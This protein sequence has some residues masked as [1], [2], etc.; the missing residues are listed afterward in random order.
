MSTVW[1]CDCDALNVMFYAVKQWSQYVLVESVIRMSELFRTYSKNHVKGWNSTAYA[2]KFPYVLHDCCCLL[3]F[4]ADDS[5]SQRT[6]ILATFSSTISH[7]HNTCWN[8]TENRRTVTN[9][10]KHRMNSLI[11]IHKI[12]L[13]ANKA[14]HD[15]KLTTRIA[16]LRQSNIISS[17]ETK[18]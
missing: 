2:T 5:C 18:F 13:I 10:V 1:W 14:C 16:L 9:W 4:L 17:K 11:P 3:G 8:L 12:W 15:D 7:A 6:L